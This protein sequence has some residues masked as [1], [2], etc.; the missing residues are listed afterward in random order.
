MKL[1]SRDNKK[2]T[3][4]DE[5]SSDDES[6]KKKVKKKQAKKLDKQSD[7]EYEANDEKLNE[8]NE[9]A[10]RG[11]VKVQSK[12]KTKNSNS[13]AKDC[14]E[15]FSNKVSKI[16]NQTISDKLENL[17]D[18]DTDSGDEM[19]IVQKPSKEK[20]K[21]TTQSKTKAIKQSS[22]SK[23][24]KDE[25]TV[26]TG[27]TEPSTSASAN[28]KNSD[29]NKKASLINNIE[30][31]LRM[32]TN[33]VKKNDS[34]E[35]MDE[36][37]DDFEEVEMENVVENE[38]KL[39]KMSKETI[40]LTIDAKGKKAGKKVDM[41]AKMER[42]L[43]AMKKKLN[44]MTIK[45][46]LVCWLTH[47]FYLNSIALNDLA[48]ACLLSFEKFN[49]DKFKLASLNQKFLTDYLTKIKKLLIPDKI[50]NI[51]FF[52][53]TI[54]ITSENLIESIANQTCENY[55][56]YLLIV[57]I[58][59]R[60]LKIKARLNVCFDVISMNQDKEKS[61]TTSKNVP[62]VQT[63]SKQSKRKS[64][65]TN[66]KSNQSNKKKC[67]S[68]NE[69]LSKNIKQ[70]DDISE[71]SMSDD[72]EMKDEVEDDSLEKDFKIQKGASN[73]K[74]INIKGKKTSPNN[75]ILSSDSSDEHATSCSSGFKN[76]WIEVY[77]EKE[78]KWLAIEPYEIKLDV[79]PSYFFEKRFGTRILYVCAF[80]NN[81]K[82]KDVTK[83]YSNDWLIETRLLRISHLE[84]KKLWWEKT[85]LF[86][87]PLDS[88]LD[89]EE[90]KELKQ[91]LLKKSLPSSVSDFKDHPLYVL[92]RHLLKFQAIYPQEAEAIGVIREEPIY[93]RDNLA[94]LHSRQ[95]WLKH[96]RIVKP[97]EKSYKIVKGRLK[98]SEYKA[99]MR[100]NPDLD[101]FGYWQTKE[102][103][104]P[105]AENGR[106]PR[107]EFGNV[108][109]F[110]PH[111]IPVGCIHLRNMPNL[112][113]VCRKLGIDVAAAV[114]GFDA[115]GGFSH[116][117]CD[118]WVLCEEF[119]D[120]V[121][122]AYEEERRND[123]KKAFEKREARIIENW[124][125][126]VK[127]VLIRE[128]LK[129]K[130]ENKKTI[131]N[132]MAVN[133]PPKILNNLPV[134]L[135]ENSNVGAK[136]NKPEEE[137]SSSQNQIINNENQETKTYK[138]MPINSNKNKTKQ[139][140][141][142][143]SNNKRREESSTSNDE[144]EDD[145]EYEFKKMVKKRRS[146]NT[147]QQTSDL[148]LNGRSEQAKENN[149]KIDFGSKVSKQENKLSNKMNHSDLKLSE[150]E[151][152]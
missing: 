45:T 25:P 68:L 119:K 115:H 144:D 76:Y 117:V 152:E 148:K 14:S 43:K 30:N 82:V 111:M 70:S 65:E 24:T 28:A 104:P 94:T 15:Y 67:L 92:K 106:V 51:K 146:A 120:T 109:L 5:T 129:K 36:E 64:D 147:I 1:R 37:D 47:G 60:N 123:V 95:T 88:M 27:K 118:G 77:V 40:Q 96:A 130:Y 126:L 22:Q 69:K 136:L 151:S 73:G 2:S 17:D 19:K 63:N 107:N 122:E 53:N 105:I 81:N 132:K 59:L 79:G 7:S 50:D 145:M 113:R 98:M 71:D 75:K 128:R 56:Q 101:L 62:S 134:N 142:V 16:T 89:I 21:A 48:R 33:S 141:K 13:S 116:A 78:K 18:E 99:G 93:L 139:T 131:M 86:H 97:F 10:K 41:E 140:N 34:A 23:N 8:S 84:E 66:K 44:I 121:L 138:K 72:E 20:K 11:S 54:L 46:H 26:K 55:L 102:F 52:N 125:H 35:F 149:E 150:S 124:A 127:S 80:D 39:A 3:L 100:N 137:T 4:K 133:T 90:E 91:I 38:Q 32:E 87:Q 143:K 42:M 135:V 29:L 31:L 49:S 61:N 12:P 85:L 108:E 57:L 114:V 6:E 83:R 74:L 9:F 58:A 112:N 110:Q 103:E